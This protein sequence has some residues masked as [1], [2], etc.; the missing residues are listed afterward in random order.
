[1]ESPN[2]SQ[3]QMNY[4]EYLKTEHWQLLRGAKLQLAPKCEEC[5]AKHELEVHHRFYRPNWFD[6]KLA[7][8]KTL[9]HHCHIMEHA[10]DWEKRPA[11]PAP[12]NPL[13]TA[14][15]IAALQRWLN[16]IPAHRKNSKSVQ[17]KRAR[18][19]KLLTP[20]PSP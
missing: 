7:D 4:A 11:P 2:L 17:R 12:K 15:R 10:K 14:R 5:G 13:E 19:A 8:L 20:T 3:G 16:R 1:M 6:A 9:C 18:L